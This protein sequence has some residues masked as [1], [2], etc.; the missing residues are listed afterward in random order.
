[1]AEAIRELSLHEK[2]AT[3]TTATYLRVP[4]PDILLSD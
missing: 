2:L 4:R 1:M 3:C